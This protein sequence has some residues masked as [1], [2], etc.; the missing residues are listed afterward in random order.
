[1]KI[2]NYPAP[3]VGDTVRIEY[4]G[5]FK[6][7]AVGEL[8]DYNPRNDTCMVRI[9]DEKILATLESLVVI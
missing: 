5:H 3:K 8:T 9:D 4:P 1:M 7:G 6:D 2:N